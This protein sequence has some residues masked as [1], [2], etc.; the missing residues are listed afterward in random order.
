MM[1]SPVETS[2]KFAA[3]SEGN[4]N[5][6]DVEKLSLTDKRSNVLTTEATRIPLCLS[7]PKGCCL[8][9]FLRASGLDDGNLIAISQCCRADGDLF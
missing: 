6:K 5:K 2:V 3:T 1:M 7:F 9:R 8:Y 4:D